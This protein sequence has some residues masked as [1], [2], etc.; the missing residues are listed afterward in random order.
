MAIIVAGLYLGR[1]LLIPIAFS[2]FLSFLLAPLATRLERLGLG[3]IPGSLMSVALAFAVM[4]GFGFLITDQIISLADQLPKYEGNIRAKVKSVQETSAGFMSRSAQSIHG[5]TAPLSESAPASLPGSG[6]ERLS[7]AETA[8]RL[9]AQQL[10][11]PGGLAADAVTNGTPGEEIAPVPVRI[12]KERPEP[13]SYVGTYGSAVLGPLG[14]AGLVTVLAI[15]ILI[16]RRDVRDRLITLTGRGQIFMTTQAF[17]DMTRRISRY[18]LMQLVVNTAYAIPVA[19]GLALFG[20]PN[21]LLWGLMGLVLRFIPYVGA[22]FT[23]AVSVL[24]AIAV[25]PG[26]WGP[27][28]VLIFFVVL[29]LFINNVIE[30]WLY[31]VGTGVSVLG[32]ILSAVFWA[33]VWGPVGLILATPIAVCLTVIGKYIPQLAFLDVLFGGEATLEPKLRFFQRLLAMDLAEALEIAEE[34]RQSGS[35]LALYDDI[36]VPALQMAEQERH[37]GQVD[38]SKGSFLIRAFRDIIDQCAE[39]DEAD[40]AKALARSE[41][42]GT[43][44]PEAAAGTAATIPVSITQNVRVM[45]LP[46]GDEA[47][48]LAGIMLQHLLKAQG[49]QV[50]T[51]SVESLSSELLAEVEEKEAHIVVIS[52]LPPGAMVAARYLCKRVS[53]RWSTIPILVGL[54]NATGNVGFARERLESCGNSKVVTSYAVAL[55][56]IMRATQA[57]Q[58]AS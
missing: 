3:K 27:L 58:F 4:V 52:A 28:G 11:Q 14:T 48:E 18:L 40:R 24:L 55:T 47:D 23:A 30:P 57:L 50:E 26:W 7:D 25:F 38:E 16:Q 1:D 22:W 29:E 39:N 6:L 46:A 35:L 9:H 10:L 36:I 31:S 15:F 34:Y 33:W 41:S 20:I 37:R 44:T 45:C 19:V 17:D 51:A 12:V 2:I 42:N 43:P 13:L 21:A 56:E 53:S 32:V 54:W 5:F 49:Y 8:R